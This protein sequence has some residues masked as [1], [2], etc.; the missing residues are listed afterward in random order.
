MM[1][2]RNYIKEILKRFEMIDCK[3]ISTSMHLS[4]RLVKPSDNRPEELKLPYREALER[5]PTY[6]GHA[7]ILN[8]GP[9]S[10]DA[11]KQRTVALSSA[12]AE[13]MGITE[14][15]KEDNLSGQRLAANPTFHRR[16]KDID[17]GYHF[18]R[19]ALNQHLLKVDYIPTA[20]MVA[21][22]LT[23]ALPK[24]KKCVEILGLK[25]PPC[26]PDRPYIKGKCFFQLP[27][28]L[29]R[30]AI[31]IQKNPDNINSENRLQLPSVKK[32]FFTLKRLATD[33]FQ[34][35]SYASK[36]IAPYVHPGQTNHLPS[37]EDHKKMIKTCTTFRTRETSNSQ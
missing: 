6:T 19:D 33:T 27:R 30:E 15:S 2:Q 12:E 3:P 14:A 26:L 9:I 22:T 31:E 29:N 8:C 10:W 25:E 16:S 32:A 21:T 1:L 11:T 24:H 34:E 7:F 4:L 35:S 18:I 37:K 20:D 28:R 5:C 17:I 13:Y 23:K 36:D